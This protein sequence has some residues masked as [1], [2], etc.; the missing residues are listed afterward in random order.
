VSAAGFLSAPEPTAEAQLLLDEDVAGLGYVMN[1]SRLW[2]YQPA[3]RT[4]LADLTGE[5]ASAH[6]LTFRER[7]ILIAACAS[8][9]GDSYCSLAWGSRLAGATDAETASG[10]L[11]GNDGKLTPAEQAMANWARMVARDPNATSEADVQVLRDAGFS[12][13]QIFAITLFV[14]LRLAF[15]TVNDA[16]GARPDAVFRSTAPAAVLDAVAF[17]RPIEDP[18]SE[19]Q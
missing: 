17:G 2:A 10:V 18:G 7:G 6:G 11:T 5:V 4:S 1:L 3:S 15:S 19:N 12:D 8:T 9:L 13:A 16:L 14:A